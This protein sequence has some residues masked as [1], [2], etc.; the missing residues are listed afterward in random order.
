M[1][2]LRVLISQ[3]V[4]RVK[5]A[6]SRS[7]FTTFKMK[8]AL[9]YSFEL[10]TKCFGFDFEEGKTTA[11][12][13]RLAKEKVVNE[14]PMPEGPMTSFHPGDILAKMQCKLKEVVKTTIL[15]QDPANHKTDGGLCLHPPSSTSKWCIFCIATPNPNPAGKK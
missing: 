9:C 3:H 10:T 1:N 2:L 11:L 7:D 13:R 8:T 4:V 6:F 12:L 14:L 15:E 5:V